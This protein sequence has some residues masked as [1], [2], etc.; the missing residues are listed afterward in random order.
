M[1]IGCRTTAA[2]AEI[3]PQFGEVD[4]F[5][6]NLD[7]CL[8]TFPKLSQFRP[9]MLAERPTLVKICPNLAKLRQICP[10]T[11][12][13]RPTLINIRPTWA[14]FASTTARLGRIC[15]ES[16]LLEQQCGNSWAHVRQLASTKVGGFDQSPSLSQADLA[17]V[18]SAQF[19]GSAKMERGGLDHV[20]G[21]LALVM[22]TARHNP[23]GK[24]S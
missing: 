15:A 21:G 14:K 5:R 10:N 2:G 7:R 12:Q 11:G 4:N 17:G 23:S 20:W 24:S 8:P 3:R 13:H 19:G 22:H 9:H 18:G 16:R 6:L 1:P